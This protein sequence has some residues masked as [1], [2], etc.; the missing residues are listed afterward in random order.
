MKRIFFI[1]I[2]I[3]SFLISR[4]VFAYDDKTTHPALTDEIIDFFNSIS[5]DPISK[6]DRISISAEE[7]EWIVSGSISEDTVPRWINHFYD[8]IYKVGWNGEQA[9]QWISKE[10][11]QKFSDV[12]L[13]SESAVSSL[14][15]VHNQELQAKYQRYL[16]NKTWEKAIYEYVKN[17][18]KQEAYSALGNVLHL[19]EDMA[20]PDHTR[21][22]THPNDSPYENYASRYTRDNI[23]VAEDIKDQNSPTFNSLDE[24]FEYLANYSN[25]YFFSKDTINDGKYNKP[26]I[27]RDD[28]EYSYG[29]D[30]N[31]EELKLSMVKTF[32]INKEGNLLEQ[33]KVYDLKY[34]PLYYPILESYWTRLSR[35]AV[36]NGVGVIELFFEE[37]AKAEKD[38]SLL[39]TPPE[40]QSAIISIYGEIVK[41][42][43][44]IV[45]A[46]NAIKNIT[47]K[48]WNV[49]TGG[50][51][52]AT[53]IVSKPVTTKSDFVVVAE[54]ITSSQDVALNLDNTRQMQN[55]DLEDIEE[56]A[57]TAPVS[58]TPRVET[59]INPPAPIVGLSAE[60]RSPQK[61]ILPPS[62]SPIEP[63]PTPAIDNFNPSLPYP[64]FGGGSIAS[65][66]SSQQNANQEQQNTLEPTTVVG[67]EEES[68]TE[69]EAE[70]ESIDAIAPLAPIII[71]PDNFS[72]IFTSTEIIFSGTSEASSTVLNN[73]NNSTT[74]VNSSGNWSFGFH[75]NQGTTTIK[76]VAE[77][78]AG[79][80]S[81]S[82][83]TSFF[84]DSVN[85]D[86]ES[87]SISEC[88]NSLSSNSCLIATTT[89]RLSWQSLAEDVDYF[90]LTR[91]I[92]S[93]QAQTS[94]TTATSTIITVLD[95]STNTFSI[96]SKDIVGNWSNSSSQ[97]VEIL[98]MPVVINEV[99]WAGALGH[100]Q[101]EW[102]E[103]YNRASQPINFE[104]WI[105]YSGT[106]GK[107]YIKLS[108]QISAKGY[109]LIERTDDDTI[110]D[111]SSDWFGSFGASQGGGAGLSN[112]GEV[113]IL[114]YA[115]TTIDQTATMP[116]GRWPAGDEYG[117]TMERYD[118]AL[119]GNDINSWTSNNRVIKNGKSAGPSIRDIDGTP[120]AR[121]SGNYLINRGSP[122]ITSDFILKKSGSPY[123]VD[124]KVI[125]IQ[126]GVTFTIEPGVTIQFNGDAG[127]NVFGTIISQ[128]TFGE[129]ITF[130]R[131]GEGSYWYGINIYSG[132][133]S[134]FENSVLSYGGKR[135]TGTG[136]SMANLNV[137][138]ASASISNSI[139]EHSEYYG[140]KLSN[141]SSTV[142]NNI[143]RSNNISLDPAGL[144]G[145]LIVSGGGPV[146]S[147]N[148]FS[149]NFH[150]I[151]VAAAPFAK[152]D[153][154]VF[155]SNDGNAIS[156]YGQP[157]LFTDNSGNSNGKNAIVFSGNISQ[158]N[159][160]TTLTPNQ[161]AYVLDGYVTVPASS[162]LVVEH[163]VVIKG[164]GG[165]WGSRLDIFGN[166]FVQGSAADDVVFTS[167]SESPSAGDW[168][169]I[170]V[171]SGSLTKIKGATISY[172]NTAISYEN[173]P[174]NL[175]SVKFENNNLAVSADASSAGQSIT[176]L[177]VEFF[178][179]AVSMSPDG[180]W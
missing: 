75:F 172:A 12:I 135:Y 173:S 171:Y 38:P 141:S 79:N 83:E 6:R 58:A 28:G 27:A 21:N 163:G 49:L 64:G 95:N 46:A 117:I 68:E 8:P 124:N 14:N 10:I 102:I 129:P 18:N 23:R 82:T 122:N 25:N 5:G 125:L 130:T 19:L 71:S 34:E 61:E 154:N 180:L 123:L 89:L 20:V 174:I 51:Q 44:T 152:I 127:I 138:D 93:G 48:T 66:E 101:D 70:S 92:N 167:L 116:N 32:F 164:Y 132:S 88:A 35:A 109:Y 111:I 118:P 24:Y 169:G 107:P 149:E 76:F 96:R 162:A 42:K 144:G 156:S 40:N 157:A 136:T 175:E 128:G 161:L 78:L 2:L 69:T 106:D 73:F 126:S 1:L 103:L 121:N 57:S 166:L 53:I 50:N 134:I 176:A 43:T 165:F 155:T 110:S 150:G 47:A 146:I 145:A 16:G 63:K 52:P 97:V 59:E 84:I 153:S 160:T 9:N 56:A 108:G 91:S 80:T 115:S 7:K 81:S 31:Q 65:S 99:A 105:L 37:V 72:R 87:F 62:P 13:S 45:K 36:L 139:F 120:K 133:G 177:L 3:S 114:A 67:G 17:K 113:L 39:K 179:N 22:D 86:L 85:P 142:S 54:D 15:W 158:V 41:V 100:H 29:I 112:N 77:D 90:E 26:V 137:Q 170:Y 98:L 74:T 4:A 119:I 30:K 143:F 151:Y 55:V 94:T 168:K 60:I 33:I 147:N 104:N 148:T 11:M 131:F 140:L 159:A 178:N